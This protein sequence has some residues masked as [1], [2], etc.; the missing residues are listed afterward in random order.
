MNSQLFIILFLI[1]SSLLTLSDRA[2]A[3]EINK[4]RWLQPNIEKICCE[5]AALD[6]DKEIK[7]EQVSFSARPLILA[8]HYTVSGYH[9]DP[10][11]YFLATKTHPRAPPVFLI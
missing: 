6:Q 1:V 3:K 2:T 8:T 11:D 10:V 7:G 9:L 4:Q 5:E